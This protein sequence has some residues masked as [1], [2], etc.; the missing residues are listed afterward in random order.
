MPSGLN[1]TVVITGGA[2]GI[3]AATARAFASRGA[4]V[5][6]GDIDAELAAKTAN[7]LANDTGSPV[8][9]LGV[10]VTDPGMFESLLDAVVDEL[11]EFDVLVNN[12]GIMPTGAFLDET[13]AVTDR[14]IDINLRGVITG[15]KLAGRRFVARRSGHIVNVA[16]M[17]GLAP[18]PGVAV[19]CAT[20]HAV[21]GLSTSIQQEFEREGVHVT[22]IAPSFVNTELVSGLT[23]SWIVRQIGFIEPEDVAKAIVDSVAKGKSGVKTV[24]NISGAILKVTSPLPDRVRLG[25]SRV[26]GLTE[27]MEHSDE[28]VR[29]AYRERTESTPKNTARRSR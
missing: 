3:G 4:R 10:D 19:Y 14:Q 12:A 8:I 20:K 5:A 6:I 26:M 25:L 11:G 2:R 1:K 17:A 21:V 13:D 9:G 24:P 15:S 23:P 27:V 22:A 29:A 16:S 18:F 28:T 7:D